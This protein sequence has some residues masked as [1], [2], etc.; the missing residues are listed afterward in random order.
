MI[1]LIPSIFARLRR[2]YWKHQVP[3]VPDDDIVAFETTKHPKMSACFADSSD[4]VDALVLWSPKSIRKRLQ[5]IAAPMDIKGPGDIKGTCYSFISASLRKGSWNIQ[6]F[7]VPA[8]SLLPLKQS[9]IRKCSPVS[10]TPLTS[11]MSWLFEVPNPSEN[12]FEASQHR[13]TS[14]SRWYQWYLQAPYIPPVSEK[15]LGTFRSLQY[16]A[17]L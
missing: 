5:D 12:G 16:L 13:W 17:M 14:K 9:G 11:L 8:M 15:A 4:I 10:Q 2:G 6:V 1:L 3:Q 7:S